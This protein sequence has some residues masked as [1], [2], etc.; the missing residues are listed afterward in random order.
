MARTTIEYLQHVGTGEVFAMRVGDDGA[1]VSA[2]GPLA[3]AE[4]GT[5]LFGAPAVGAAFLDAPTP[6]DAR[7]DA[8]TA[9]TTAAALD[10]LRGVTLDRDTAYLSLAPYHRPS[11]GYEDEGGDGA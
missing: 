4:V 8:G 5:A 7:T 10:H 11:V 3:P 6:A 2:R 9:G 1:I